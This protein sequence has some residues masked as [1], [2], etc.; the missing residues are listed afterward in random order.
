[1]PGK[2]HIHGVLM[3]STTCPT[4][5]PGSRKSRS[6]RLPRT[7]PRRSPSVTAQSRERT[8]VA[9]SQPMTPA[10]AASAIVKIHVTSSPSEKAAP[11]LRVR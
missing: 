4:A 7:P 8:R 6:V 5:N 1:M 11:G 10:T 2:N 9:A 3:K